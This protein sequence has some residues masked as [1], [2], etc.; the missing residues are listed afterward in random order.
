[1]LLHCWFPGVYFA[2]AAGNALLVTKEV[3]ER[4]C[5]TESKTKRD[6]DLLVLS[7]TSFFSW[8]TAERVDSKSMAVRSTVQVHGR[9][10]NRSLQSVQL[11]Q[12]VIVHVIPWSIRRQVNVS[13][14]N[15][16]TLFSKDCRLGLLRPVK[17][18][19][20]AKL[21]LF[22]RKIEKTEKRLKKIKSIK[23]GY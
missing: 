19:V 16:K 7:T 14:E 6:P 13:R 15:L 23:T 18:L 22:P 20:L 17:Q 1:M 2:Y 12:Q 10:V 4:F 5:R 11:E 8:V 3:K 9:A 21:L